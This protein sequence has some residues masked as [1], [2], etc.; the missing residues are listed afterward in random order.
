MAQIAIVASM[1]VARLWKGQQIEKLKDQEAGGYR[2]AG[3]RRMAA[4]T[5]EMSEERRN[6][7]FMHS[8]ALAVAAMQT[9][10]TADA[11]IVQLLGDLNAEGEYRILSRLWAGQD[12]AAGWTFRAEAAE[13]EG[14]AAV[15]ASY[16]NAI[17]T[18]LSAGMS[19]SFSEFSQS[20]QMAKGTAAAKAASG[21]KIP[22]YGT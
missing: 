4:A 2:D 20:A 6:K 22:Q 11:G 21:V 10:N 18:V 12:D 19:G 16:V 14:K 1:A 5:R 15:N 9:G 8:R 13:R 17:T 7:E 3:R